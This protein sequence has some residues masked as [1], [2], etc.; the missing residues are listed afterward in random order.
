MSRLCSHFS[1][2]IHVCKSDNA[3]SLT[4]MRALSSILRWRSLL[5]AGL[6]Y[7]SKNLLL[8]SKYSCACGLVGISLEK[9]YM[10]VEWLILLS[11]RWWYSWK[12][13]PMVTD[14]L[15]DP[16]ILEGVNTPRICI[17]SE[18]NQCLRKLEFSKHLLNELTSS[19]WELG[20]LKV[21]SFEG[22]EEPLGKRAL[23]MLRLVWCSQALIIRGKGHPGYALKAATQ[24][25]LSLFGPTSGFNSA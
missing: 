21:L 22:T 2:V 3:Y 20:L 15:A 10:S 14:D 18:E 1:A 7:F 23:V 12:Y 6:L 9:R 16:C 25:C 5:L 11:F 17:G 13:I 8:L 19:K 24:I 4:I